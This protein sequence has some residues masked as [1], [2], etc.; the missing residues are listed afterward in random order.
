MAKKKF[1]KRFHNKSFSK[2]IAIIELDSEIKL[3]RKENW[4]KINEKQRIYLRGGFF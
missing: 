1:V 3:K 4:N 2:I